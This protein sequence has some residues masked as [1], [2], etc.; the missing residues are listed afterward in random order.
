MKTITV[1]WVC[2]QCG[3]TETEPTKQYAWRYGRG[4][5]FCSRECQRA[6]REEHGMRGSLRRKGIKKESG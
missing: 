2:D 6:W 4:T 5:T 3:V 1:T